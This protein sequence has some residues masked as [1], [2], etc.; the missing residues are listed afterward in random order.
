[1]KFTT[2]AVFG[3]R[4]TLG[5]R[6][7]VGG[8]SEVWQATDQVL[9]RLVAIKLLSPALAQQPGFEQRFREEARNTAALSHPNIATVY[10]Y[11]ENDG[12]SWLVMELVHGK[13]LSAIIADEGPQS[14]ERTSAIIGQAA[15]ALHAAHEA[16][17]VHR[18]V[19]P[20]NIIVRP[21]GTVKLTDF[22]ISRATDAVPI[23]RTGEVMGTAQYISPEQATGQS[24][25]PRSDIYSLGCVAH[26]MLTG[27]RV[28]DEGSPVATAMAH[29]SNPP[30]QLPAQVPAHI[31]NVIMACLAKDPAQRPGSAREVADAL[32]G[33]ATG[34]FARTQ[35]IPTGG[36]TQV[37][38][39]AATAKIPSRQ[40]PPTRGAGVIEAEEEQR[41][42]SPLPWILGLLVVLA[43]AGWLLAQAGVFDRTPAP[44]P[45][46]SATSS[47]TP[48]E[49]PSSMEE[50]T[51]TQVNVSVSAD[52]YKG[53]MF[54]EAAQALR[55]LGL[56][57][58]RENVD[59]DQ[60][61]GTVL[62]VDPS[63]DV[64]PGQTITLTVSR[65]PA[66]PAP[67]PTS[68]PQQQ[69]PTQT[70][71]PTTEQPD[72]Q[73]GDSG[74]SPSQGGQQ[75]TPGSTG[76]AAAPGPGGAPGAAGG[77][78]AGAVAGVAQDPSVPE[79][80]DDTAENEHSAEENQR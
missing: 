18:D 41:R 60:P 57:V 51:P 31:A 75:S 55:G 10:D 25:G 74:E 52:D 44:A 2:G 7:A 12:A 48:T 80:N 45:A 67:E 4:Y 23:T 30:A 73:G 68:E 3:N 71:E 5:D 70:P 53:R 77:G 19:K 46:P 26:E 65:G 24:V 54:D 11:G 35:A 76:A 39:A 43:L 33:A 6:I 64:A 37:M 50:S 32:R 17:V 21:D 56:G 61:A 59:S 20:A 22:G 66:Q 28:F 29:V 58:R 16:G 79:H 42:S 36:A 27:V 49:T 38:G 1:M 47:S 8:M 15:L 69:Q 14:P 78:P 62:G 72:P 63:G 40:E 9:G 34:G 13:P